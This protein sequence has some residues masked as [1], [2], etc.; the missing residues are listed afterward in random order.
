MKPRCAQA[1]AARRSVPVK[2]ADTKCTSLQLES[3][4]KYQLLNR[5]RSVQ[6]S[7]RAG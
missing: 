7:I 1:R 6:G 2:K 3:F 5:E 4:W